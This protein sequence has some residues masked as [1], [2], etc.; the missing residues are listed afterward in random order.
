[1]L[2]DYF[3]HQILTFNLGT[4]DFLTGI[5]NP[6]E[7]KIREGFENE[8]PQTAAQMEQVYLKSETRSQMMA[9]MNEYEEKVKEQQPHKDFVTH[10]KE[11][12]SKGTRSR[13]VYTT[14]FWQQLFG[15]FNYIFYLFL[16]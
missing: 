10:V 1:M 3:N 14:N 2:F 15:T 12:K 16:C 4:P 13:S 7:R 6:N 5:T 9:E 11:A 8:V